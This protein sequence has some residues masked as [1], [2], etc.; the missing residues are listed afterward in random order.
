[1]DCQEPICSLSRSQEAIV[2]LMKMPA[3]LMPAVL[4]G[5][6]FLVAVSFVAGQ[7]PQQG[8]PQG[9][10]L[11][12]QLIG[13][14]AQADFDQRES[15][16][17]Q[18][19]EIGSPAVDLLLE[20]LIDC[21]PDVCS[22]IKRILQAC[23]G[24]CDEES[25]FKALGVLRLRFELSDQRI[26]PLLTQWTS[27]R[28]AAIV[29]AWRAQGAIVNDPV[30]SLERNILGAIG[31][32]G[33][34]RLGPPGLVI[35]QGAIV[36]TPTD[37]VQ[38]VV[39]ELPRRS[40]AELIRTVL[41]GT[42]EQN[43]K[44]V[45]DSKKG[46]IDFSNKVSVVQ[47]QPVTVVIGEDWKGDFSIFDFDKATSVLPINSLELQKLEINDSLL[48]AIKKQPLD[49]VV[50]TECSV[51]AGLTEMLPHH[52]STMNING[53]NASADILRL[54]S[55]QSSV[56][57]NLQFEKSNFGE[58]EA[59][60]L[61]D[62]RQLTNVY[63]IKMDLESGAF[64]G[65]SVVNSLRRL[66]LLRCKFPASAFFDFKEK[67]GK[68]IVVDF[69]PKSFL[70]V[71]ADTRGIVAQFPR[72]RVEGACIITTVVPDEGADL[73]GMKIGDEVVEMGGHKIKN[74]EELRVVIAQYEIGEEATIKVLRDGKELTLKATLGTPNE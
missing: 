16:E 29:D 66:N 63:L 28:R 56:L 10:K 60:M 42:L 27:R 1:M 72:A 41:A 48:R 4:A 58:N 11:V 9:Q 33:Q 30:E 52:I 31:N 13:Q 61:R 62:F 15:A 22:R 35:E 44:L 55:R 59:L 8:Q 26:E 46:A 14:L 74:F 54:V 71:S 49:N 47:K 19:I 69:K 64:D 67:R 17:R 6:F 5:W 3:R 37:S 7:V 65:L 57:R 12:K 34:I 50:F 32:R 2:R 73:A 38:A 40:N 39:A 23:P 51:A 18:L 36:K 20:E 68:N 24:K 25:L 53:S 70:G 43:K 45:L 21:K